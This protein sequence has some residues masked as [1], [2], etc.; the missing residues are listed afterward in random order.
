MRYPKARFLFRLLIVLAAVVGFMPAA[1]GAEECAI[2]DEAC[3]PVAKDLKTVIKTLPHDT[4]IYHY[5]TRD[6]LQYDTKQT[7][8]VDP[9][10]PLVRDHV[11]KWADYFNDPKR[12]TTEN[13][14]LYLAND[15]LE[16]YGRYGGADF[17]MYRINLPMGTRY[18]FNEDSLDFSQESVAALK[19]LG[20]E[21]ASFQDFVGNGNP[22]VQMSSGCAV[23][24]S[25]YMKKLHIAYLTYRYGADDISQCKDRKQIAYVLAQPDLIPEANVEVF[26]LDP[27]AKGPAH[28]E[29]VMISRMAVEDRASNPYSS[30]AGEAKQVS[31][32]KYKAWLGRHIQ[33]CEN[34]APPEV[35]TSPCHGVTSTEVSE[36]AT[37]LHSMTN[38][39]LNAQASSS[40]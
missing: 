40:R 29:A 19:K 20:C 30:L 8:K 34:L 18:L 13:A 27:P 21:V 23:A 17:V 33:G 14:G 35:Q 24:L 15:P 7:G 5:T 32:D 22:G 10:D 11:R 25:K 36:T 31:D 28:V 12:D 39:V 4:Y 3:D 38:T 2:G 9:K 37:Q 26:T 6:R 1:V 16:T